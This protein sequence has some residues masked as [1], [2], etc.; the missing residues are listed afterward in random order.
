MDVLKSLASLTGIEVEGTD[1]KDLLN[2]FLGSSNKGRDNVVLEA[3]TRT[4]YR[5][6]N[7]VMIPP[8]EGP[9][10]EEKVNIELGNSDGYL[11]FNLETDPGQQTN[12]AQREAEKLRE[13]IE[14]FESIRGKEYKNIQSL[15]LK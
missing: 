15:E 3:T 9:S 10:V 8:Y 7:W 14:N 5:E 11:L 2:T 12:L 1:S 13:M 6:G 4:A